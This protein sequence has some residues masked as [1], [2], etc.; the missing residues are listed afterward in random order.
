MSKKNIEIDQVFLNKYQNVEI[1]YPFCYKTKNCKNYYRYL[2]DG[3][4]EYIYDG[5]KKMTMQFGTHADSLVGLMN[6]NGFYFKVLACRE[7]IIEN[8]EFEEKRKEY[9]ENYKNYLNGDQYLAHDVKMLLHL[10]DQQNSEIESLI[11]LDP[12]QKIHDNKKEFES[13]KQGEVT[14]T[15]NKNKLEPSQDLLKQNDIIT[16]DNLKGDVF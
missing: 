14:I 7:T 5:G 1:K 6:E 8:S 12:S 11:G 3:R 9:F 15:E 4:Y 13:T 16:N 10:Q 2:E